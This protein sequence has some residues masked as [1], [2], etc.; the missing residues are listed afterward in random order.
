MSKNYPKRK[1]S[2]TE[3]GEATSPGSHITKVFGRRV[4]QWVGAIVLGL[5]LTSQVQAQLATTVSALSFPT[6]IDGTGVNAAT[7]GWAFTLDTDR[8]VTH[9]GI[10][11]WNNS[12]GFNNDREIGI[13]NSLGTLVATATIQ[14]NGVGAE[15]DGSPFGFYYV[16]LT[17]N[18]TLSSSEAYTIGVWYS[19]DNNPG[20]GFNA[21]ITT[22]HGVNYVGPRTS[23]G[24]IFEEPMISSTAGGLFGPNLRF[25][26]VILADGFED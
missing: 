2:T 15:L 10:H 11:N 7:V 17:P 18:I 13:W 16:A 19:G 1:I 23:L 21:T 12:A 26:D 3:S 6:P 20:V 5:L 24:M 22:I 9:L 14:A 25:S 4:A 8:V